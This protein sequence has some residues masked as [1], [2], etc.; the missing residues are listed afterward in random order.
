MELGTKILKTKRVRPSSAKAARPT[1]PTDDQGTSHVKLAI[2]QHI[3]QREECISELL[4]TVQHHAVDAALLLSFLPLLRLCTLAVVEAI[5]TWQRAATDSGRRYLWHGANYLLKVRSD[6]DFLDSVLADSILGLSSLCSNPFFT[7]LN[8][9]APQLRRLASSDELSD[10][11]V[12]CIV[13]RVRFGEDASVVDP[14]LATRVVRAMVHI[15]REEILVDALTPMRTV[16]PLQWNVSESAEAEAPTLRTRRSKHRPPPSTETKV[17]AEPAKT[18]PPSAARRRRR[19]DTSSS[20]S[21]LQRIFE[22]CNDVTTAAGQLQTQLRVLDEATGNEQPKA[23]TVD[24]RRDVEPSWALATPVLATPKAALRAPT[25]EPLESAA[26]IVEII[27][28]EDDDDVLRSITGRLQ[29]LR[30]LVALDDDVTV[31]EPTTEVHRVEPSPEP[32]ITNDNVACEETS[33]ATSPRINSA[34]QA[35]CDQGSNHFGF[36]NNQHG[37]SHD[38]HSSSSNDES[39][40]VT[41]GYGTVTNAVDGPRTPE[42]QGAIRGKAVKTTGLDGR[43]ARKASS[44]VRTLATCLL[45][46]ECAAAPD[47]PLQS[48]APGDLV[49]NVVPRLDMLLVEAAPSTLSARHRRRSLDHR[50]W[51]LLQHRQSAATTLQHAWRCHLHRQLQR[52]HHTAASILAT[53]WRRRKRCWRRRHRAAV[54]IQSKWL[55][56]REKQRKMR[57]LRERTAQLMGGVVVQCIQE[58]IDKH[59]RTRAAGRFIAKWVLRVYRTTSADASY[60]QPLE[61][62]DEDVPVALVIPLPTCPASLASEETTA[63]YMSEEFDDVAVPAVVLTP[64]LPSLLSPRALLLNYFVEWMTNTLRRVQFRSIQMR[65]LRHRRVDAFRIWRATTDDWRRRREAF[66]AWAAVASAESIKRAQLR[67][68][69]AQDAKAWKKLRSGVR[70]K[71]WTKAIE[72]GRQHGMEA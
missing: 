48:P 59:L 13:R 70:H 68:E 7:S 46:F 64:P 21:E 28:T 66:Q 19:V 20:M 11:M 24:D 30:A 27:P 10:D 12:S 58:A 29:T 65:A 39:T 2:L 50:R 8:L 71:R 49:V 17:E 37:P 52:R 53:F 72:G 47:A 55:E 23:K 32:T 5:A 26:D 18:S 67:I 61:A 25:P 9:T 43:R 22:L 34:N 44:S 16:A 33:Q 60:L 54:A 40:G 36:S 3:L 15:V 1:P 62:A 42:C 69:F 4:E 51:C 63:Y 45:E 6:T 41:A 38:R 14:V 57:L 31:D 56:Y 35:L